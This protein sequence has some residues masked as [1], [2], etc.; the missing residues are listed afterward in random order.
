M[1][2]FEVHPVP[3]DAPPIEAHDA[4]L[5]SSGNAVRHAGP[6]LQQLCG[7][8]IFAVGTATMKAAEDAG[9]LVAFVGQTNVEALI[10]A[11]K[12]GSHHRL[13]WLAGED[14]TASLLPED[15][16]VD[17]RTVYRSVASPA[18]KNFAAEV[19]DA[20]IVLLHSPRAARHFAALCD[21]HKLDRSLIT[22]AT[23]SPPIAESGGPGWKRILV[24]T[25]PNDTS[26]LSE[27]QSYFTNGDCDP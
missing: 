25:E 20:E 9:L 27:V 12:D 22:L 6:G 16:A 15:I 19:S 14:R 10:G 21:D 5:L 13:L 4:L 11:A 18:P 26:L 2:L 17:I 8:P 24:A 1:P 3:W 7:L 23:L